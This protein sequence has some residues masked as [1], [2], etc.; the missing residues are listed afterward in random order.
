MR[1]Q[2]FCAGVNRFVGKEVALCAFAARIPDHTGPAADNNDEFVA[3]FD[4]SPQDEDALQLP[5]VH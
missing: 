1:A 3:I 5:H 4:E 2:R